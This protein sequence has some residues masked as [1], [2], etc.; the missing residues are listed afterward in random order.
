MIIIQALREIRVKE[1]GGRRLFTIKGYRGLSAAFS[2]SK[3]GKRYLEVGLAKR[4]DSIRSRGLAASK[5]IVR[6]RSEAASLKYHQ[7][8]AEFETG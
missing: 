6:K 4:A 3:V 7:Q 1:I 5:I 2:Y 8:K